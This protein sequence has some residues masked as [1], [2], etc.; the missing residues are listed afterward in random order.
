MKD[1][2]ALQAE[3]EGAGWFQTGMEEAQWLQ[4]GVERVRRF[5]DDMK[6]IR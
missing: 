3:T 6:E 1:S 5:S 2:V 4:A